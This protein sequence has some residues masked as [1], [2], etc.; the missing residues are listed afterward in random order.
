MCK[1]ATMQA[2]FG[3]VYSLSWEP[4]SEVLFQQICLFDRRF[5]KND[6]KAIGQSALAESYVLRPN[7]G[8]NTTLTLLQELE[9]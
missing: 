4:G 7:L 5:N 6:D 8:T 1:Y 9:I 3:E 2:P